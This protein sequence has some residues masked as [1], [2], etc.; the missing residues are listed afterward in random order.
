MKG[1]FYY[2]EPVYLE[3]RFDIKQGD[4]LN[5]NKTQSISVGYKIFPSVLFSGGKN[6]I[7]AFEFL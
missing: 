4:S 3:I 2:K 1:T 5:S 6:A 7:F